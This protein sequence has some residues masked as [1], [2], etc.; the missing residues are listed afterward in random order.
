MLGD[1]VARFDRG[2]LTLW[3]ERDDIRTQ[4]GGELHR[5][6]TVACL[7]HALEIGVAAE[8][9]AQPGADRRRVIAHEHPDHERTSRR[10]IASSST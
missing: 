7:A 4:R 9:L 8:D 6:P 5:A 3:I 2:E 10:I 1:V